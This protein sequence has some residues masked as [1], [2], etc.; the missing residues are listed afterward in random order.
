MSKITNGVRLNPGW[1]MTLYSCTYMAK[2]GVKGLSILMQKKR[3]EP[4]Q[5]QV[6]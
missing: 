6:F 5:R 4:L 2:M 1:Y 3:T